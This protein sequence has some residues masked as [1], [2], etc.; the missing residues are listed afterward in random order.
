MAAVAPPRCCDAAGALVVGAEDLVA[1]IQAGNINFTKC[2]AT[3]DLMPLVGKVA[4]VR[5]AHA[6]VHGGRSLVLHVVVCVRVG[7]AV[8]AQIL[9]PKGL[10]PNPKLGTVTPDVKGAVQARAGMF[11]PPQ[12]HY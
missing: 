12:S 1:A 9:G 8:A 11:L 2:I 3:P 4:R 7:S 5:H 6:G 10:M